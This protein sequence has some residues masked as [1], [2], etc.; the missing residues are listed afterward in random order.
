[1]GG[2]ALGK[3]VTSS[4]LLDKMDDLIRRLV[5][6]RSEFGV[7]V[8]LTTVVLVSCFLSWTLISRLLFGV[9]RLHIHQPH[10]SECPPCP[11]S[12]GGW[13]K[14]SRQPSKSPHFHHWACLLHWDGDACLGVPQSD[15]VRPPSHHSFHSGGENPFSIRATQEDEMGQ[16]YLTNVDFLKNGVPAS[17]IA[18]LVSKP[19]FIDTQ[20]AHHMVQQVVASLGYALMKLIRCVGFSSLLQ[21][22]CLVHIIF[23][24]D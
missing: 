9:D 12:Q 19:S 14:P 3:G 17:V 18:A 21:Y 2:V 7:I 16:L 22:K 5:E 4:G 20:N 10:N 6:G 23:R 8:V 1:M 15:C 11:H 13:G 24:V